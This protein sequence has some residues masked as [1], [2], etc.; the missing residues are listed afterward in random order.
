MWNKDAKIDATCPNC[1]ASFVITGEQLIN[2]EVIQ[3]PECKIQMD[4]SH[5][6]KEIEDAIKK[7]RI[8]EIINIKFKI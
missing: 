7:N 5:V 6:L 1:H 8:D 2:K 4:S 3:C